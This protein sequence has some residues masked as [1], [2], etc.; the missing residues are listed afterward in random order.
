METN[1]PY[2]E[3]RIDRLMDGNG[4]TKAIASVTIGGAFAIHGLRVIES[5]KGRFVAMPQES[6]RKNGETK[7]N[8]IFHPVTAEARTEIIAAVN[9][10]FEQKL[11][12]QHT[13]QHGQSYAPQPGQ[14]LG[15]M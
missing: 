12:Q 2:V 13:Q 11:E 15:G 8:D 10:A 9:D 7:Y 5:A 4:P 1:T 3:A 14:Q 6:Y